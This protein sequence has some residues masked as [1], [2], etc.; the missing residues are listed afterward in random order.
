MLE[1]FLPLNKGIYYWGINIDSERIH[2]RENVLKVLDFR[3]IEAI[4]MEVNIVWNECFITVL[5]SSKNPGLKLVSKLIEG[6]V[7]TQSRGVDRQTSRHFR[8]TLAMVQEG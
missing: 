8:H 1:V 7:G 6:V 5:S 2:T 4:Y 3:G